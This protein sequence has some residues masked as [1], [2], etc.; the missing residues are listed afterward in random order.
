MKESLQGRYIK[1]YLQTFLLLPFGDDPGDV[2]QIRML[3]ENGSKCFLNLTPV[4]EGGEAYC[5]Y[6]VGGMKPMELV[7][8]TLP[9][10]LARL[11]ALL[12]SFVSVFDEAAELLLD[13]DDIVLMPEYVFMNITDYNAGFVYLPGYG[14][15]ISNLAEA[16]FECMLNRVDYDD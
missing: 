10:D 4:L 3:T 7:F 12:K 5:K 11:T 13:P 6:L 15:S 14:K 16:F 8:R 9:I 2:Y 1:E